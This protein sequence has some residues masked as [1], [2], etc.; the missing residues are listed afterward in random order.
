[1]TS[2][3]LDIW[4]AIYTLFTDFVLETEWHISTSY[5]CASVLVGLKLIGLC[6]FMH[7]ADK[8]LSWYIFVMQFFLAFEM[9][10]NLIINSIL[11]LCFKK[12][13]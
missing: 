3:I 5:F 10:D 4:P 13:F 9:E 2:D 12:F 8:D 7:V 6:D 11:P 1:M